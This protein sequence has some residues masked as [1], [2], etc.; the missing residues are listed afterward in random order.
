MENDRHALQLDDHLQR[1]LCLLLVKEFLLHDEEAVVVQAAYRGVEVGVL[2]V[3]ADQVVCVRTG[4]YSS[5][6]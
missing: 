2:Y 1:E 5:C 6:W 3:V 4:R